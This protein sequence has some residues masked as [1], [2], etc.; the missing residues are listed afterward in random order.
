MFLAQAYG[1][2]QI[3]PWK[4]PMK[5]S[6]PKM[7]IFFPR[8]SIYHP[9]YSM[10][11]NLHVSMENSSHFI[12]FH[13]MSYMSPFLWT[14]EIDMEFSMDISKDIFYGHVRTW[15]TLKQSQVY[16]R[17]LHRHRPTSPFEETSKSF[18]VS[19]DDF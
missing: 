4:I 14:F 18:L 2:P 15:K 1:L 16:H 12:T 7:V 13:H 3:C 5:M 9:G 11:E 8:T 6:D 19:S 17:N 10:L